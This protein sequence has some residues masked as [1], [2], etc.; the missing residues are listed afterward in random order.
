MQHRHLLDEVR[1]S[2]PSKDVAAG[3]ARRLQTD[4]PP[5]LR[6]DKERGQNMA[7]SALKRL[8]EATRYGRSNWE[9]RLA[10]GEPT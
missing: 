2:D 5:L 3:L 10:N 8:R 9:A 6:I 4:A 7:S 1:G